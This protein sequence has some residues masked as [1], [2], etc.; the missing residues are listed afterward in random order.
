MLTLPALIVFAVTHILPGEFSFYSKILAGTFLAFSAIYDAK[1]KSLNLMYRPV[2]L[3]SF[4]NPEYLALYVALLQ[5]V[6]LVTLGVFLGF[7]KSPYSFT[8][9]GITTNLAYV[10]STTVGFE[11]SRTYLAKILTRRFKENSVIIVATLYTIILIIPFVLNFPKNPLDQLKFF[12]NVLIPVYTQQL[13]ASLLVYIYGARGSLAY[14]FPVTAFEWFSPILPNLNWTLN[15]LVTTAMP[16]IGYSILEKEKEVKKVE[17]KKESPASWIAFMI[18]ALLTFL[19]FTGSFGVHPAVVGSG[20]MSPSIQTG[21]V[22]IVSKIDTDDLN[23]GDIIQYMAE[24]Y[25]VTHRIVDIIETDDGRFF[26]TKGD[27]NEIPDDPISEDRVVGKVIFVVP[28][29]GLL[30]LG[31]KKMLEIWGVFK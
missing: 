7:G 5:I 1:K 21:D 17:I 12:G 18:I 11:L 4:K 31:I 30:P 27:A 6:V 29:I 25:T 14:I 16:A 24:G 2:R 10:F 23:I 3:K 26:V 20:S 15:A 13:F 9:F 8:L 19:F 28:K 22:I